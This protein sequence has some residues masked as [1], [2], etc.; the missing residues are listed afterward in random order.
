MK[1]NPNSFYP[2]LPSFTDLK[3]H[4]SRIQPRKDVNYWRK[5]QG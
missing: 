5:S 1:S 3:A 4:F 2:I